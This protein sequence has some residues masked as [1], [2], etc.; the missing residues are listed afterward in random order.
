MMRAIESV[1]YFHPNAKVVVHSN[2]IPQRESML[3]IFA[4]A[5]YDFEIRPYSFEE[6]FEDASFIDE[7]MKGYFLENL[8]VQRKQQYWYTHEADL[9]KMLIL[10]QTGGV[11]MDTDMHLIKAVPKSFVNVGAW[12]DE[13]D[14]RIGTAVLI[15]EKNNPFL[16]VMLADA[17][18]IANN[19]YNRG[20]YAAFVLLE[21]NS[22]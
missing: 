22:M 21:H 7:E 9:V 13:Q 5:G 1:F 10:E 11:M 20:V 3:D 14:E 16:R 8:E 18:D 6:L 19:H 17:I 2:T 12:K 4:E 15:F